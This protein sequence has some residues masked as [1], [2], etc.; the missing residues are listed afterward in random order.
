MSALIRITFWL[1]LLGIIAAGSAIGYAYFWVHKPLALS[2][3][4]IDV[5]VPAG[6]SS[7][8]I[9]HLLVNHGVQ[10]PA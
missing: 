6:A 1:I 9:A 2:Q 8:R 10:I 3:P 4:T 5:R 7:T